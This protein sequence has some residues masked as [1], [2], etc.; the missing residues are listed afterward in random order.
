ME[1]YVGNPRIKGKTQKTNKNIMFFTKYIDKENKKRI[2]GDILTSENDTFSPM[3][4]TILLYDYT[5]HQI[6]LN[7]NSKVISLKLKN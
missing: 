6:T 1:F 2:L 7:D 5:D 3:F 4:V